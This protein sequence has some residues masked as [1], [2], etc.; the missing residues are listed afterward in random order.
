M[1]RDPKTF[2]ET[3]KLGF[4]R[5][6]QVWNVFLILF[7]S[8]GLIFVRGASVQFDLPLI[9]GLLLLLAQATV[10][11]LIAKR[12]MYTRQIV[13]GVE[14]FEIVVNLAESIA[15][16]MFVPVDF[17]L[18]CIPQL[19][20]ITY[21]ATSRRAKAVLVQPWSEES[22]RE[23]QDAREATLWDPKS[24]EF[25]MRLLIYFFAFSIMGHWMEMGVQILVVNGIMPGTI[26]T[27]DSLTWRDSLNP[28]FI[29]GIAVAFC[30]LAL[31]PVFLRLR[32]RFSQRW[33]AYLASFLVNTLFCVVAELI[34]GFLFNAD[35]SAWD[36][37]DQFMN[38][39][40]Q[41]CLL[42]TL[43]FGVMA[44]FITWVV[45]PMMERHV[46]NLNRDIFR[47]VF[48]VACVLFLLIYATYNVDLDTLMPGEDLAVDLSAS[49][50]TSS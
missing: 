37:R 7:V 22:I 13:I 32:E 23:A 2:D 43:A 20:V 5:F 30:G 3:S 49:S 11:W 18:S 28:F 14:V 47:I 9:A 45:Y 15:G 25:W 1:A 39:M 48:V 27:P 24:I 19:I 12:K 38:F 46:S 8:I 4:M 21:F 26:A 40:G 6:I 10:I 41:I 16:D 31:Y 44:S 33:K 35:Y 34:L 50:S 42:Y 29:Y 36:Y 17:A